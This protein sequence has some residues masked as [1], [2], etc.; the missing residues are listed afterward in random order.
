MIA[1]ATL[2]AVSQA[3][4]FQAWQAMKKQVLSLFFSFFAKIDCGETTCLNS[5][6]Q[7]VISSVEVYVSEL[8]TQTL[9]FIKLMKCICVFYNICWIFS[10]L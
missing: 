5:G 10:H 3:W 6:N 4:S 8:L 9:D 2:C 1:F 7:K